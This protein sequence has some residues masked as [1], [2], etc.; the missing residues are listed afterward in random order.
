M[1]CRREET[2]CRKQSLSPEGDP[3]L[4]GCA[5]RRSIGLI[6][7]PPDAVSRFE[8][9]GGDEDTRETVKS[10]RCVLADQI[11]EAEQFDAQITTNSLHGRP[12]V[13]PAGGGRQDEQLPRI[14]G[15]LC[16]E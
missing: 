5:A 3:R 14:D 10:V 8:L 13:R 9:P 16:T 2:S 7:P 15:N 11:A 1:I 12:P 4:R 6:D